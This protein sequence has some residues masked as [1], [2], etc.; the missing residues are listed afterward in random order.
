MKRPTKVKVLGKVIKVHYVPAGHILLRDHPGDDEPGLGRSDG[1]TQTIAVE[2][3][4]PLASE[5]DCMLHE[6]LHHVEYAMKMDVPEE[7]VEKFASGL[8]AVMKDNPAL[9]AYL[10][11]KE[12]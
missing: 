12:A 8:L 10:M 4:Q 11:R 6:V 7:I 1:L 5:Q 3:A 9:V 2:Q